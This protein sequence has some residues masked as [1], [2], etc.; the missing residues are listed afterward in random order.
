MNDPLSVLVEILEQHPQRVAH[1]TKEEQFFASLLREV[2]Q[3][4][5]LALSPPRAGGSFAP[6]E[7]L[8]NPEPGRERGKGG[9]GGS[10]QRA[11]SRLDFSPNFR[12]RTLVTSRETLAGMTPSRLLTRGVPIGYRPESSATE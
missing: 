5:S 10:I 6:Y 9:E 1:F 3:D 2:K 11:I 7:V 4:R 12:W 8:G